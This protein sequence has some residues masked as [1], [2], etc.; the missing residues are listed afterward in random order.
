MNRALLT[1]LLL[2]VLA[3]PARAQQTA[4]TH[5]PPLS[6]TDEDGQPATLPT[7]PSGMT[8]ATLRQGDALY[9]RKGGCVSCHGVDATGVPGLG[10]SL[11]AGLNYIPKPYT[12][13]GLDSLEWNGIAEVLTRTRVAC[14]A[15]GARHDLTAAEVRRVSAY[16]W[17]I[18]QVRG[19]PWFG[20][21]ATHERIRTATPSRTAR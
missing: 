20:G 9:R 13:T 12:W 18:A 5:A 2:T 15:R 6:V 4:A 16:V 3:V 19:E 8:E 21:H 1:L 17:A 7:L 10:S 14:P 11:T